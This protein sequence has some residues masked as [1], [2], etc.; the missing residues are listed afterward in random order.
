MV[1]ARVARRFQW[2]LLG[3]AA[4]LAMAGSSAAR[5]AVCDSG[6]A[7]DAA[8]NRATYATLPATPFGRLEQGW[9]IYE[10]LIMREIGASCPGATPA[11]ASALAKWKSA[12][13]LGGGGAVDLPTLATFRAFWAARRPFVAISK[14][15][16]PAPPPE[17]TLAHAAPAES[18]GGKLIELRPGALSAYRRMVQQARRSPI[19]AADHQ[20]FTIFSGFRSP[21]YDAARCAAQ[22]NCNG[23]VR[24]T[25]SPHRTGLAMD[26][27]LG[28]APGHTPDST[29]DLNRLYLTRT[30]A[31]RWLV[32]NAGRFGFVNYPFEPWHWE[33]TG[34]RP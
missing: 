24:A 18:F 34:E 6:P 7:G 25:C 14:Q 5:A 31:Y 3:G 26:I 2:S 9:A 8:R 21:A 33:W 15:S 27:F 20:V 23:I 16:C 4:L 1:K 32:A 30:S 10:P 19:F 12:H 11:F 29:D 13:G 28:N 17:T 22:H